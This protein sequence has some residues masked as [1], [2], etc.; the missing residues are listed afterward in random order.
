M[1]EGVVLPLKTQVGFQA[2]QSGKQLA[3]NSQV[4]GHGRGQGFLIRLHTSAVMN[5][6]GFVRAIK[7]LRMQSAS[8][9]RTTL[10][11]GCL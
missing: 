5:P 11:P 9:C 10:G 4:E 6:P 3:K 1:K 7:Q 2:L 8:S